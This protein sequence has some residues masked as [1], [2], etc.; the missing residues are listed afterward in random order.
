MTARYGQGLDA[1]TV[2]TRRGDR[3][4]SVP[5][6]SARTVTIERGLLAGATAY[7]STSPTVPGY[8]STY[9]GGRVIEIT[10]PSEDAALAAAGTLVPTSR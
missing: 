1:V 4:E 9:H 5:E 3:L 7:L 6:L 8:L 10:A 2:T